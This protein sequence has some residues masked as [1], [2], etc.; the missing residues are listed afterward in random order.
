MYCMDACIVAY[1]NCVTTLNRNPHAVRAHCYIN[2]N[3]VR[4]FPTTDGVLDLRIRGQKV[5]FVG[6][7]YS[8]LSTHTPVNST[9]A[10]A[11]NTTASVVG[12]FMYELRLHVNCLQNATAERS[13]DFSS[14]N[15]TEIRSS[16]FAEKPRDA[17]CYLETSLRIKSRKCS[18]HS[19]FINV[20]C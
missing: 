9:A 13:T 1:M 18:Q 17:L 15:M 16:A 10:I 6:S 3:L 4:V 2:P 12:D 11:A 5:F 8:A 14:V 7:R 19:A 20:E